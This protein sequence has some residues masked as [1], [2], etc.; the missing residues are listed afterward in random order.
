L[1]ILSG[2]G[3]L[4][5]LTAAKQCFQL[6]K[7]AN[8]E[9]TTRCSNQ[10][11]LDVLK[12]SITE[13]KRLNDNELKV[14]TIAARGANPLNHDHFTDVSDDT[15]IVFVGFYKTTKSTDEL[16]RQGEKGREERSLAGST[17]I[18]VELLCCWRSPARPSPAW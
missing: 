13:R 7:W 16:V 9:S 18:R 3:L 8:V 12:A 5:A 1:C 17:G 14:V 6:A 15:F 2:A 11:D 4:L 10:A